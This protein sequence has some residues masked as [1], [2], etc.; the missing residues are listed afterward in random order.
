MKITAATRHRLLPRP[1]LRHAEDRDRR[2]PHRPRRRHAQRPRAGGGELPH[3]PRDPVPDR[4]RRAPDRGHLAVPLQ[5]A[6]WRR[7]P[8]TM[9]AIAAVDTALWDIK[10]KAAGLPLYQ[11]LGGASRDG[12][13]VYGHANG[14]RHRARPSTRCCATCEHGLQ[15]DPRAER[16][17][18]A[19]RRPTASARG[20]LF[21]EPAD[22]GLPSE[23]DWSTPRSTCATR[24][25]LFERAARG[26]RPRHPPAARRAPPPDADRGRAAGQGRWSPTACSG[27]RTRRRP[28]TRRPS[29]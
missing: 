17:A 6:Y 5:G 22:A 16:R 11:L 12:V 9:S 19:G 3:R 2:G 29:G 1:Q 14:A 8:V 18:G 25:K 27:W 13:M 28:R 7:G 10:A 20:K 4:P 24:R 21:Y 15:G 26:V 23:H